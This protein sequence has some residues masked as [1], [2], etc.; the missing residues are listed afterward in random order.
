ML[1]KLVPKIAVSLY[2]TAVLVIT[3]NRQGCLNIY[4]VCSVI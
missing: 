4:H 3:H 2:G 1:Y